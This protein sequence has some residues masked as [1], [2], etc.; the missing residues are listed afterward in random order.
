MAVHAFLNE[1]SCGEDAQ[2]REA[3]QAM[4][5]FT[6]AIR[7]LIHWRKDLKLICHVNFKSV[8]LA[9]GYHYAQW[10]ADPNNKLHRDFLL[11]RLA[12]APPRAGSFSIPENKEF[13]Y[14]DKQ[15][16]GLGR[17]SEYSG[18]GVSLPIAHS[19]DT[20]MVALTRVNLE[21]PDELVEVRH[22]SEPS[23]VKSHEGWLQ[24]PFPLPVTRQGRRYY[25]G[26]F[27]MIVECLDTN[28]FYSRDLDRHGG[29]EFKRFTMQ[30]DG[31][32]WTADLNEYGDVIEGKHK[33][34]TGVF[35]PKSE[36]RP[37]L[38]VASPS[39]VMVAGRRSHAPVMD[40]CGIYFGG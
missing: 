15:A 12:M 36:L 4:A 13:F 23:H 18:I 9:H 8:E 35:I 20:S 22:A 32:H 21:H 27:R 39:A 2:H 24:K 11:T 37:S 40:A 1:L 19:W 31:L 14:G 3:K 5:T 29:S 26:R 38:C 25:H 7:Q 30:A 34:P 10:A 28:F 17:A 6:E 16:E 33:G